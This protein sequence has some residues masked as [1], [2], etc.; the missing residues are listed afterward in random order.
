M[1]RGTQYVLRWNKIPKR[2]GKWTILGKYVSPRIIVTLG[3]RLWLPEA[4]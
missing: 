1:G 2:M 3:F 4:S